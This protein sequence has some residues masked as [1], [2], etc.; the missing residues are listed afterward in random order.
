MV[1]RRA[2]VASLRFGSV[3]RPPCQQQEDICPPGVWTLRT[4][5]DHLCHAHAPPTPQYRGGCRLDASHRP[6]VVAAP[7]SASPELSDRPRRRAFTARDKLHI[8]ATSDHAAETR[9]IGALLCRE[10]IYSSTLWAWGRRRDA[11]AFGALGPA[12]RGPRTTEPNAP[13]EEVPL[14]QRRVANLTRALTHAE[15][16]IQ[17]QQNLRTSRASQ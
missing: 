3:D 8:F 16:I 1:A 2:E 5:K 12:K 10:G 13:V 4:G 9:G 6:T 11:G 17:V 14:L 7:A 15:A